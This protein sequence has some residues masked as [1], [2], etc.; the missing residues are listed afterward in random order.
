MISLTALVA[1]LMD[2]D[3]AFARGG[4]E[5]VVLRTTERSL[6]EFSVH[7]R[8]EHRMQTVTQCQSCPWK[9]DCS[10]LE[11]IPN[12]YSVDLHEDLRGTIAKPG[13]CS[14][15]N[16]TQRIMACHYSKVGEEFACAGWLNHQLGEGNN[17][18]LRLE[19]I[20]GRMPRPEVHGRQ[21]RSFDATLPR[22]GAKARTKGPAQASSASEAK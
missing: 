19:V 21:H 9:V 4:R 3:G 10:P 15:F 14:L 2:Q 17:V 13:A 1:E 22:A 12:G 7:N 6:R 8:V 20:R 5:R 16:S 18:W 11:D